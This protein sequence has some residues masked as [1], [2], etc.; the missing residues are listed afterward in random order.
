MSGEPQAVSDDNMVVA[1][2]RVA[3]PGDRPILAKC[4]SD[5]ADELERTRAELARVREALR[6]YGQHD[7][8]CDKPNIERAKYFHQCTCG[9]EAALT[10][11]GGSDG[12]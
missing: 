1:M 8:K 6:K 12:K 5:A 11:A 4:M 7:A 2:L 3:I 9:L 10:P